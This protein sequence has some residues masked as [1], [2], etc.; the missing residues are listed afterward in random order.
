[1]NLNRYTKKIIINQKTFDKIKSK[2]NIIVCHILKNV[3]QMK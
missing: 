2:I 3:H 1:M